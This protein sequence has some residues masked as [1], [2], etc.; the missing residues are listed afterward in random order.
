MASSKGHARR[1]KAPS[2]QNSYSELLDQQDGYELPAAATTATESSMSVAGSSQQQQQQHQLTLATFEQSNFDVASLVSSLSESVMAECKTAST[3]SG[4]DP[5]PLIATFE[6]A[7]DQ[8]L[9]LR[10]SLASRATQAEAVVASAEKSYNAKL[11]ELKRNFEAVSG[12]YASLETRISEVGRTAIRIGEQL[13]SI[14]RLKTRASDAHDLISFYFDLADNDT[15]RLE[16]LRKEN[17]EGRAKVALLARR[18]LAVAKEVETMPGGEKTRDHVEKYCEKFEK[19]M[20][21]LFD[22]YYRNGDPRGM[23]VRAFLSSTPFDFK[24]STWH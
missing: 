10:D 5:A 23:G 6:S 3:P 19:E 18:L 16:A 7:V 14:D 17:R 8:L 4:F 9:P 21:R 12:S 11:Q 13:E 24:V 2:A 20:L 1:P 15:S 22:R